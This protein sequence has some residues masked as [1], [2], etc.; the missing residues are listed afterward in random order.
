[1]SDTFNPRIPD[2]EWW[3]AFHR[4]LAALSVEA[5]DPLLPYDLS[6]A[7]RARADGRSPQVAALDSV[8]VARDG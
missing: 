6:E 2:A 4:S 8:A 5:S 7:R 3:D 1:M